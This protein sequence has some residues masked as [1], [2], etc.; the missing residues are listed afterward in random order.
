MTPSPAAYGEAVSW[1]P[2]RP[3]FKPLR[4]LLSWALTA[5]SLGVAAVI[6]P[7]VDIAGYGGALARRRRGRRAERGAPARARGAA[8]AVHAR[9][10]L[11]ARPGAQRPRAPARVG[12]C[13][14]TPS[15]WTTS[16]G[17][18]SRRSLVAAVSVVLEVIFGTN[19]DDTYTLRVVQR[20]ARRQGG[21]TRTDVPGIIYLEI[22]G[23]AL[24]VLRRAM[25]DGNAP[26]MARW[27]ARRHARADRVGD[28]PLLAD[29]SEPGGDPARLQRRHP[30]VPLGGQGERHAHGVLGS[31]RLRAHRGRARHGHR[32]ARRR[33]LEPRQP[34]LGR[35]RGGHPHRQPH[36][37]REAGEP[38]LS[39]VL[40]QR[41]QRHASARPVRVGGH[42]RVDCGAPGDPSRR[43]PAR[44]TAA[45]ST[46]SCAARCA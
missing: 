4:L 24:P 22:D 18:C 13:W 21:A 38:R 34:A 45:A 37:G 7:G 11:R 27:V 44:V 14:T 2:E 28:R 46:R 12:C 17:R 30:G 3:R 26:N 42:P 41:V 25:R 16:A 36:G 10:R 15:W 23:L 8:P 33:R 31:R 5:A 29:G 19:D 43:A 6:L 1:Q 32:P 20:I 39:R 40:R 35:G 9:A